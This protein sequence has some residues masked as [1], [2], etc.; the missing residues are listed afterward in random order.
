MKNKK[1]I[2]IILCIALAVAAFGIGFSG[3][4]DLTKQT[5]Q[6]SGTGSDRLIGALITADY[7]DLFDAESYFQDNVSH[8]INGGVVDE[9]EAEKYKGRLYATSVPDLD[10]SEVSFEG[11]DGISIFCAYVEKDGSG[12]WIT[13]GDEGYNDGNMH[14]TDTDELERIEMEGTVYSSTLSGW[15]RFYVN[16]MYQTSDGRIYVVA[17]SGNSFGGDVV[18]GMSSS[19]T[20]TES[21]TTAINGQSKT[22]EAEIKINFTFMDPSASVTV[23]Q[24]DNEN[25]VISQD[26]YTADKLPTEVTP[27]KAA[28]YLVLETVGTSS[29]GNEAIERQLFQHEDDYAY[30]FSVRDDGICVKHDI[31]INWN[32]II[33]VFHKTL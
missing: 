21:K 15:K 20:L 10:H 9:Q 14:L 12:C 3:V 13:S 16:P 11:V 25:H 26:I 2:V 30:A 24:F 32:K 4:I 8:I 28:Q 29:D 23:L 7:L 22:I 17:G 27:L 5:E 33:L 6:E 18:P 31:P 19:Q 1:G